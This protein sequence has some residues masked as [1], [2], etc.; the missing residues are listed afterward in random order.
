MAYPTTPQSQ[1]GVEHLERS[2]SSAVLPS[3]Q[4]CGIGRVVVFTLYRGTEERD[5]EVTPCHM[6]EWRLC[7]H[8]CSQQNPTIFSGPR[9]YQPLPGAVL[10]LWSPDVGWRRGPSLMA[11]R[12]RRTLSPGVG[13]HFLSEQC[14][15]EGHSCLHTA[16]EE[17]S[18][19]LVVLVQLWPCR[20]ASVEHTAYPLSVIQ[21][22]SARLVWSGFV[23]GYTAHRPTSCRAFRLQTSQDDGKGVEVSGYG[24]AR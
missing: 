13:C 20:A 3:Q 5:R 1:P 24:C 8:Q 18:A 9:K 12:M 14:L 4:P 22:D 2:F 17:T 6:R 10:W 21:A 16:G 7:Q 11:G 19:E 15:L 23:S